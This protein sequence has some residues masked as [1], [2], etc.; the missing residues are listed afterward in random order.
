[1]ARAVLPFSC[2]AR[3]AE[4]LVLV[5]MNS[6]RSLNP[7]LWHDGVVVRRAFADAFR[8]ARDMA[9]LLCV[10]LIGAAFLVDAY[11]EAGRSPLPRAAIALLATAPL[12]GLVAERL[13]RW[14]LEWFASISA[15]AADA[16]E[17]RTRVAYRAIV[18]LGWLL[19]LAPGI[20]YVAIGLR[21]P[22]L[23]PIA[24]LAG[25]AVGGA[26]SSVPR[27]GAR[28]LGRI[29]SPRIDQ[30]PRP[31]GHGPRLAYELLA[32]RQSGWRRPVAALLACAA[33][34]FSL[35]PVTAMLAF[36]TGLAGAP[37]ND[38]AAGIA[39]VAIALAQLLVLVR[40][41]AD[42]LRF[43]PLAGYGPSLAGSAFAAL[44]LAY[45]AGAVLGFA[46][47][48]LINRAAL[49]SVFAAAAAAFILAGICCA[50]LYPGRS[51][52]AA[53]SQMQLE[54]AAA[55]LCLWLVPPAAAVAVIWRMSVLWRRARARTWLQQ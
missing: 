32:R 48:P 6:R 47:S 31:E 41:D 3:T 23:V 34:G 36:K 10:T 17:V 21:E 37:G 1:M 25:Y 35:A 12:A 18:H 15:L 7:L 53:E 24:W 26:L 16:L 43:L 19:L 27:A 46:A 51:K 55:V 42:M 38:M 20:A 9:L 54:L 8:S 33:I 50:W 22:F 52:R 28:R 29:R 40:T 4:Y 13:V 44:P 11:R 39:A 45:T 2:F 14:R 49:A 5:E 30:L